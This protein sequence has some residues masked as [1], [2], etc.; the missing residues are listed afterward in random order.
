MTNSKNIE[1]VS[2]VI[3]ITKRPRAKNLHS[4]YVCIYKNERELVGPNT[5]VVI[6]VE[7]AEGKV[8]RER[9]Y[10][11]K[12]FHKSLETFE[13]ESKRGNSIKFTVIRC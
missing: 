10:D 3:R 13:K 7:D 11:S 8:V 6:A 1:V 9:T 12:T 2:Q 5:T 4:G